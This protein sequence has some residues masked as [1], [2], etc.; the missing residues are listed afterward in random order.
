MHNIKV[1]ESL[2][3]LVKSRLTLQQSRVFSHYYYSLLCG[4]DLPKLATIYRTDKWGVHFYAKHYQTHFSPIKKEKLKI[5]EIGIGGYQYPERGGCSLRMWRTYFPNSMIYGI[6]IHDKSYHDEQRIKT[7]KGSQIDQSFLEEVLS[8]TEELD[9]I[10]D[11]GSHMNDHVIITFEF[12][13][14][15]LKNG[16]IYV[17]EDTQTSYLSSFKGSFNDFNSPK[18]I[19]GYF[20]NL[21]DGLN[22]EEIPAEH[23]QVNYLTQ[24]IVALYFYHNLIFIYKGINKEGSNIKKS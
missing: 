1:I 14:P 10:I 16:G 5:L 15:K 19:M 4:D 24:N 21:V 13:F 8:I 9:I 2:K 12:L 18:T 22:Y 6:D 17:V 11:D 7:F 23:Y 3:K 20:K